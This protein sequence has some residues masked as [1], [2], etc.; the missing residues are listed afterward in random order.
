[1]R[2]TSVRAWQAVQ[3]I[4]GHLQRSVYKLVYDYGPGTSKEM[5]QYTNLD[6]PW[7][8]LSELR[9]LGLVCEV[10]ERV[11]RITGQIAIVWDV[12]DHVLTK[13]EVE[14]YRRKMDV[15]K[16]ARDTRVTVM[17]PPADYDFL[18]RR[19]HELEEENKKL[20]DAPIQG[21]LF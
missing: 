7:K 4:L 6:G 8:R 19:V 9:E 10:G 12:T 13:A 17:K 15:T 18:K 2:R 11:C 21:R 14:E 3:E 20:R 5:E 16:R 1:M